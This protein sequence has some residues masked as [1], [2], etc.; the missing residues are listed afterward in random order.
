VHPDANWEPGARP[1]DKGML[2]LQFAEGLAEALGIRAVAQTSLAPFFGTGLSEAW[3]V[4]CEH[5]EQRGSP[6]PRC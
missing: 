4:T 1:A 2:G 6:W 3:R 5:R